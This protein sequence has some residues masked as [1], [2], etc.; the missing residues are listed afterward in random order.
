MVRLVDERILMMLDER[1]GLAGMG[2][3][4]SSENSLTISITPTMPGS[5]QLL[6]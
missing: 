3:L 1:H 5:L 6:A 4:L 2:D